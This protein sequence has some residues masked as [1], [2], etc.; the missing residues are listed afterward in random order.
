MLAELGY[1]A[2]ALDMY[3]EDKVTDHPDQAGE[4]MNA[5][6]ANA[7]AWRQRA[8]AGL[9]QLKG[10]E[11][12]DSAHTAAIGYCFGGS[13]V[14][15]MAY[16]GADVDGVASFHGSLPLPGEGEG[17][18]IDPA[19][20]VA[21]GNSDGFIPAERVQ[22]F[23]A[24]LEQS[25]ADWQMHVYGGARHAFT[26]PDAGRYGIDNIQYDA[27]ADAR[28]WRALQGFFAEIFN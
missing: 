16:A 5:I 19:V 7:E 18:E 13:T 1:V 12:T 27:K 23:K 2:F 17:D 14:M 3:G 21:H 24:M 8:M 25:G 15:Q 4:W 10:H 6:T 28:S 11:L 26:N 20:F 9:E 22:E